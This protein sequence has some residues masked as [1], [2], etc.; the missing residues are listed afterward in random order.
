MFG[1]LERKEMNDLEYKFFIF[2]QVVI[3]HEELKG[4]DNEICV[5]KSD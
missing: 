2:Y 5:D 1:W 3:E 4:R